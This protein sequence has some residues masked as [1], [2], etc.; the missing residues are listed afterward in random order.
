MKYRVVKAQNGYSNAPV[1]LLP[2]QAATNPSLQPN[3]DR[4]LQFM[5]SPEGQQLI[6]KY[7]SQGFTPNANSGSTLQ[8]SKKTG[9]YDENPGVTLFNTVATGITGVANSFAN[10][11]LKNQERL[12]SMESLQ[13]KFY[14]NMEG[15]GLNNIP[16]YTKAGGYGKYAPMRPYGGGPLTAEGAKEI[17]RDGTVHGNPLTPA[18]KR[19]FGYIAGGGKPEKQAGGLADNQMQAAYMQYANLRKNGIPPSLQ[20]EGNKSYK[21]TPLDIERLEAQYNDRNSNSHSFF[22]QTGNAA[23]QAIKHPADFKYGLTHGAPYNIPAPQFDPALDLYMP[24]ETT[25]H[26]AGGPA[27]SSDPTQYFAFNPGDNSTELDPYLVDLNPQQMGINAQG[28][29]QVGYNFRSQLKQGMLTQAELDQYKKK[30]K[31]VPNKGDMFLAEGVHKGFLPFEPDKITKHKAGGSS[32]HIDPSHKGEFTAKA[33][34]KGQ[35]V[36]EFAHHVLSNK[37]K[38]TKSTVKQAQFAANASHFKHQTGGNVTTTT[39]SQDVPRM[40]PD[41]ISYFNNFLDYVKDKGLQGSTKLNTGDLNQQLYGDY[42]KNNPGVN[43]PLS[44]LT[45][46]AQN[47]QQ[48]QKQFDVNFTQRKDPTKAGAVQDAS[49]SPLDSFFGSE[50]SKRYIPTATQANYVNGKLVQQKNLGFVPNSLNTNTA[51]SKKPVPSWADVIETSDGKGYYDENSN[52]VK[53]QAGGGTP[54]TH[55]LP[56]ELDQFADVNAEAG[57]VVQYQDGDINKISDQAPTHAQ[58]GVNLAGVNKVLEN[59][60]TRR[61]DEASKAL[62]L[63]PDDVQKLY[64]FRPKGTLSHAGAYEQAVDQMNKKTAV[65]NKAKK[66]INML[67]GVDQYSMN[68]LKLNTIQQNALPQDEE[69]FDIAFGHQ[70]Q[71]KAQSG[72]K[73]DGTMMRKGGKYKHPSAGVYQTGG[74]NTYQGGNTPAGKTTPTGNSNAFNFQGGLQGFKDAWAP[75]LDL[76]KFGSAQDAQGAVYDWLVKNQPDVAASVWKSQGLTAKGRALAKNDVGF[77]KVA[78]QVFDSSGKVKQG[79]ELTPDQLSALSPAYADNMLGVRSV[80]PSQFTNTETTY[81]KT[82]PGTPAPAAPGTP[83]NPRV[84][85]NPKFT[86]NIPNTFNEGTTWADLAAPLTSYA[87]SLGRDPELFNPLEFN[88]LHLKQ[89]DP[90]NTLNANQGDFEAAL[91]SGNGDHQM[92]GMDEANQA[93][94]LG[95]KYKANNQVLSSYDNQNTQIKN[96]EIAYNTNVRDKNSAAAAQSRESYY[97]KVLQARDN[98]RL[99]QDQS[100]EDLSRVEQLKR[101]QNRSGNLLLKMSPAFDENGNYNGYQEQ[102]YLPPELGLTNTLQQPTPAVKGTTSKTSTTSYFKSPD[103]RVYKTV[104]K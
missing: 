94:L 69:L 39:P 1:D 5:L 12:Q 9:I 19:Y 59:T 67:P 103:G 36:Q 15:E 51:S 93:N 14:D 55:G 44:D 71:V 34:K 98:Q 60:S 27:V 43:L 86:P 104:T 74:L 48:L 47:E 61:K 37:K 45:R 95:L 31:Y 102:F 73:D 33:N 7:K 29:P 6:N 88:Q 50:T 90:T 76:S 79:V 58:G 49:I 63:K 82:T 97:S 28:I 23:L 72:I 13:P 87:D 30:F 99:Q 64:G 56:D 26:Q 68:S 35:G 100:L 25:K 8:F 70:E 4:V 38:Y 62:A 65:F 42:A 92:T 2:T 84:N 20:M 52:F 3:D 77:A 101:R 66:N 22:T 85:I 91:Q 78:N 40:T 24:A 10:N 32:I 18:Q 53:L 46:M 89:L 16:A 75:F 11:R 96:N 83:L 80:I 17:L 81:P 41:Q 57:E 21:L 54:I